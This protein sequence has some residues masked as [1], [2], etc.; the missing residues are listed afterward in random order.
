MNVKIRRKK[1]LLICNCVS[2]FSAR[3]MRIGEHNKKFAT[4][5][6]QCKDLSVQYIRTNREPFGTKCCFTN[7]KHI[8]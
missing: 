1:A 8:C 3:L 4:H 6:W 5:L 7:T 2:H